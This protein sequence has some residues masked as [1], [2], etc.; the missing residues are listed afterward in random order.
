MSGTDQF[1][2]IR[3]KLYT[4]ELKGL[5]YIDQIGFD[6]ENIEE[7]HNTIF[8]TVRDSFYTITSDGRISGRPSIEGAKIELIG[9]ID[10]YIYYYLHHDLGWCCRPEKLMS[11]GELT[12]L[13]CNIGQKIEEGLLMALTIFT[14]DPET[15]M[16]YPR[17]GM[18][19][20]PIDKIKP[21]EDEAEDKEEKKKE[22]IH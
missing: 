8:K 15:G 11:M 6:P 12:T 1:D 18:I 5:G 17:I 19:T 21:F 7:Y 10:P 2:T 3:L 20:S 16:V 22:Y 9:G 4:E 14:E 13:I